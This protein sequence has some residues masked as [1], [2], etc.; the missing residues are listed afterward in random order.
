VGIGKGT[1]YRYFANKEDLFLAAVDQ[2]MR[3]LTSAIKDSAAQ[4]ATPLE[5]LEWGV[6]G[7]LQYFD[8]RPE[9]I[10]LVIQERAY[11]R[12]RATPTYFAH[13]DANIGPWKELIEQ[14]I[15]A[16]QI[17]KVPVDRVTDVISDTLYGTIFTNFFAKRKKSLASQCADVIDVL[18]RGVLAEGERSFHE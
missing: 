7:Y 3:G 12:D 8:R 16:G 15:A 6:R 18:F 11:F 17:R 10:E 9:V 1:I 13:R 2:G 4:A 14:L 5:R